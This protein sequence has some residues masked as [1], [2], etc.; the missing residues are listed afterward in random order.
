MNFATEFLAT[1]LSEATEKSHRVKFL[2]FLFVAFCVFRGRVSQLLVGC[3]L[4]TPFF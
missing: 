2:L 1:E 3:V 4:D